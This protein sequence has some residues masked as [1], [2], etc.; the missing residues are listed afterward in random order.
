MTSTSSSSTVPDRGDTLLVKA[1]ERD[2]LIL[3][4]GVAVIVA[5]AWAWLLLGAGMDEGPMS[6]HGMP[7][8]PGMAEMTRP[9][10]WTPAYAGLMLSMWWIMMVAM[11][12]PSAAPM[13]LLFAKIN[14]RER[15]HERP[16]VR[17]SVFAAGYLLVWGVFSV[18]ATAV[19]WAL[20]RAGLLMSMSSS[21]MWLGGAL[22]VGAGL[23]QLTPLKGACLRHCRSPIAFLSHGWRGGR[24]GALRMGVE[25]GAYCLGCCW[26]L[27]ALLFFGGIMNLYWIIGLAVYV[28]LEKT[29]PMGH[30]VARTAGV[31]LLGWGLVVLWSAAVMT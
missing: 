6:H 14:R 15:E 21:S 1:I 22:L 4:T 12:L 5:A 13:L 9:T 24:V 27:M 31:G 10:A 3:V 29:I 28:L 18:L 11:M 26:F 16:Y 20:E 17:T 8:M 23:W 30:W 7:T 19:Q 2:R 25:H